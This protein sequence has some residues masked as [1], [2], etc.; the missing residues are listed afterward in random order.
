MVKITVL[1]A[2]RDT[3]PAMLRKAIESIRSQTLREFEFLILDDGSEQAETCAALEQ[4][5][6]ADA[7]IRLERGP[8]RGLTATLNRGLALATGEFIARQD[9]DDWSEATGWRGKPP[10]L[11]SILKSLCAAATRGPTSATDVRCGQHDCP[12]ATRR[13]ARHCGK[14]IL[15]CTGARY[16]EPVSRASWVATARNFRPLRITIFSGV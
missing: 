2:V 3:P 4:Q 6:A 16:F 5:A 11:R 1:M 13:S 14:E 12:R 8:R 7:R 9:A 15:S 10:S